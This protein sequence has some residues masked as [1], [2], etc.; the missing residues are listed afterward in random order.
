MGLI[1]RLSLMENDA[2][3]LMN[4]PQLLKVYLIGLANDLY[5]NY[6]TYLSEGG[7]LIQF[8][9]MVNNLRYFFQLEE[10]KTQ[11]H[12]DWNYTLLYGGP[13]VL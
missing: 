6:L 12:F 7:C 11:T 5:R 10:C 4:S 9:P 3:K 2:F 13:T 8:Q 1:C